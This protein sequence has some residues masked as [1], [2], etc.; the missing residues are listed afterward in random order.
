MVPLPCRASPDQARKRA[1]LRRCRDTA[2]REEASLHSRGR[3]ERSQTPS[4]LL[5]IDTQTL[6]Q[7]Q[8]R[9]VETDVAGG[10]ARPQ[11]GEKPGPG[12]GSVKAVSS[13]PGAKRGRFLSGEADRTTPGLR[14]CLAPCAHTDE[15]GLLPSLHFTVSSL[16]TCVLHGFPDVP[17][18]K[19]CSVSSQVHIQHR[20]SRSGQTRSRTK[21]HDLPALHPRLRLH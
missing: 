21:G 6:V 5:E 14:L 16:P 1:F 11:H 15:K 10:P 19:L 3:A 17:V 13:L 9:A 2:P 18:W 8:P 4:W 7:G 20:G 12:E